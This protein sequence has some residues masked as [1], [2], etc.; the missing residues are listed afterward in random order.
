MTRGNTTVPVME[1]TKWF[2]TN[3][4]YIMP[5]LGPDV[6]FS[7]TSHKAVNKYKKA[8]GLGVETVL[9]LVDPVSYLLLSKPNKESTLSG[10]SVL[11]ES[12]F[13]DIPTTT[14]KT[15]TGLKGVTTFRFDLICETKT[16][17]LIRGGFPEGKYLFVG[18]LMLSTLCS[19]LQ[20][21]VNLVNETK[22]DK[23]IKSWLAFAAQKVIEV[24]AL[25]KALASHKGEAFFSSN[26][27]NHIR[28]TNVNARLDAQQKKLNLP[29]FPTT[30]IGSFSQTMA[31]R[32]VRREYKA[33][34]VVE[35]EYVN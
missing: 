27:S 28:A 24:D 35:E 23:E 6:K 4:H 16:L 5:E 13:D 10:L 20:T 26:G 22:L 25:A 15:L 2:N 33:K 32:K 7:Y 18:K 34:K 14:Y 17:D 30:T 8:K 1:M 19:L 11:I 3:Y 29:I 31:L 9:V 12:Y 21:A